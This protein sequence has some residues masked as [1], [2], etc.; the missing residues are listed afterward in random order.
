[1]AKI[2]AAVVGTVFVGV[3]ATGAYILRKKK[4]P[5]VAEP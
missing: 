1:M 4:Q 2:I 5:V 3:V